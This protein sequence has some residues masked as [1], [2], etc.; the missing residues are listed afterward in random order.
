VHPVSP[1]MDPGMRAVLVTAVLSFTVLFGLIAFQRGR[2]LDLADR[3]AE[4]EAGQDVDYDA[5]TYGA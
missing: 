4:L 5:P 1:E 3:V 2:Q